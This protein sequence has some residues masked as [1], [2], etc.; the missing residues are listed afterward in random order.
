MSLIDL[1]HIDKTY[2]LG[3]VDVP[4]LKDVSLTI[5][6]GEFVALMGASGSGKTT[7][8]N[9]L[10]CLDQPTSGSYRFEGIE[11]ARRPR[12]QLARLRSSRIGFVFQAFNLM[13]RATALENVRMPSGYASDRRSQRQVR[14]RCRELLNIVGLESRV[15]HSPAQLSGGE[16]QRVAIARS[17]INRPIMLLADEPTGNLDSRTGQ[18]ILDLF[19]RLNVEQGI[20]ILMVTHDAEVARHADRVIR[21]ADGRIVND[22][23]IAARM[24][25]DKDSNGNKDS[26]DAGKIKTIPARAPLG[27][28][29]HGLRVAIGAVG[30]AFAA[31]RR[32]VMR[33]MLTMLGVII[34]VAAVICVMEISRGAST[35][36][37]TTVTNMGA[38]TLTVTP[39]AP[40]GGSVRYATRTDTLTP[41]DAERLPRECSSVAA[42]AP[43]VNTWA[44]VVFGNRN[45]TTLVTGSTVDFLK[46]RNWSDLQYGRPFT[47]RELAGSDK[48]CLIGQRL[49]K[50][51]FGNRYPVGE[52]IRVKNV[53]FTVIGV[54]NEKGATLLGA[55]QDDILFAPWT[56]VK[57]RLSGVNR[58]AAPAVGTFAEQM[59]P[60]KSLAEMLPSAREPMRSGSIE[61]IMV[62]A[63]SPA[64][65]ALANDEITRVLRARHHVSA[66]ETDFRI[67]DNAEV[68]NVFKRV[69]QMLSALGIAVAVVSLVVAGVGIMNIMLVSVTERTREIGLRM[70]V[71]ADSA[72]ILTQFLIE[73]VVLCLVGGAVGLVVGRGSSVFIS[74]L[75]GF[76]TQP[77]LGAAAIAVAVSVAVGVI[78]GYYPA[79]KASRLNPIDALRYE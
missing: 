43:L 21:I 55:D 33:A 44:P 34:G 68:S 9:V 52:E 15:S 59:P 54:L 2:Y 17:L 53:P 28:A 46:M 65:I 67:Y 38:N 64:A 70:A 62:Q 76:P 37:Q 79:W 5:R 8:M 73:A 6:Q 41:E 27:R 61:Q 3:G 35:A 40:K 16:Q 25:D 66:D 49:V 72:D 30:I 75:V 13:P 36:I 57:Y 69:V 4:V 47:A 23:S 58:A 10:G 12:D 32:N 78:F 39:G 63:V 1:Q 50:E 31:L 45:W 22:G 11:I 56:T 24:A 7:L 77:S 20:T 48:V 74:A 29:R 18:D 42:A 14:Q 51:L 19:R 26:K 60:G 71:G